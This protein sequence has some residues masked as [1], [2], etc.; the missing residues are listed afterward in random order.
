[1]DQ[2]ELTLLFQGR[3]DI[4]SEH[5]F[6]LITA[7][8]QDI[9]EP[10]PEFFT[11]PLPLCGAVENTVFLISYPGSQYVHCVAESWSGPPPAP[12]RD[13]PEQSDIEVVL[14]APTCTV[15]GPFDAELPQV[16]LARPGRQ[17]IRVRCTGRDDTRVRY[18]ANPLD[19]IDGVERWEIQIW[20][21][22]SPR[23]AL[24]VQPR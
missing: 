12:V 23:S 1:M 22:F 5:G 19:D 24:A 17:H 15:S 6:F 9:G 4:L 16:P 13:F 14:D 3:A 10:L 20:P 21:G 2:P 8:G 7:D 11:R 18:E